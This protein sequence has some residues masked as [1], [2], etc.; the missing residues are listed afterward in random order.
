MGLSQDVSSR[1]LRRNKQIRSGMCSVVENGRHDILKE[2]CAPD[3]RA[4]W[5]ALSREKHKLG[6]SPSAG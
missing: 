2:C 3:G 4:G 6:A 1:V 5:I